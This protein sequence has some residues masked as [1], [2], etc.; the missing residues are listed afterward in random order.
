[1]LQEEAAV[2]EFLMPETEEA[3]E[4]VNPGELLFQKYPGNRLRL[5]FLFCIYKQFIDLLRLIEGKF[6]LAEKRW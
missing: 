4:E 2:D 1:M 5:F 3:S 6:A